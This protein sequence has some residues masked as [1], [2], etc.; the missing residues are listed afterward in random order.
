MVQIL[1]DKEYPWLGW[2]NTIA[3]YL[4]QDEKNIDSVVVVE[5]LN[6]L[7]APFVVHEWQSNPYQMIKAASALQ[8]EA[9]RD[10]TSATFEMDDWEDE[11]EYGE[12]ETV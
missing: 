8:L 9:Y 10:I 7:T 5:L 6:D 11:G 3:A 2:L 1:S 4:E 12:P